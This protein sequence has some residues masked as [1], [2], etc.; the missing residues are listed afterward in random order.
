MEASVMSFDNPFT[1]QGTKRFGCVP[2]CL[3]KLN[4]EFCEE[5]IQRIRNGVKA[6]LG[7]LSA[8]QSYSAKQKRFPGLR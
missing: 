3:R 1:S 8:N 6:V 2:G 5:A 7:T 4:Y